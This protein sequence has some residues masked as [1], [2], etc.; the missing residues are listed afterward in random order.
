V[1]LT[2]KARQV[3]VDALAAAMVPVTHTIKVAAQSP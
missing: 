3:Y 1:A 2:E